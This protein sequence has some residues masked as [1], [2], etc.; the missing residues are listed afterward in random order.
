MGSVHHSGGGRKPGQGFIQKNPYLKFFFC[1][2]YI[3][4]TP[5]GYGNSKSKKNLNSMKISPAPK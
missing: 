1:N 2:Q 3:Q 5:N 4:N